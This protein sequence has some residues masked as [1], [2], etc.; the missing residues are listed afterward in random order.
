MKN[1]VE[2]HGQL[3]RTIFDNKDGKNKSHQKIEGVRI[4]EAN[5][6]RLYNS[7]KK[8]ELHI[9]KKNKDLENLAEEGKWAIERAN[10]NSRKKAEL[11]LADIRSE[12]YAKTLQVLEERE[13]QFIARK[14]VSKLIAQKRIDFQRMLSNLEFYP[15]SLRKKI[16]KKMSLTYAKV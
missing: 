7:K 8:I 1:L 4:H 10:N 12:Y 14:K 3:T 6:Q 13:E 2:I 5:L 9:K 16:R 11:A 15:M